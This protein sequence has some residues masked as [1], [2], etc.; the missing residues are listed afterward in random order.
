MT[1]A[2]QFPSLI[3]RAFE[4]GER[5]VVGL[6][7]D[8]LGFCGERGLRLDWQDDQCRVHWLGLEPND[9][10]EI[11]LG[12]SV[13]RAMLARIAALCN[14][15]TP[16]SV[17]AYGGEGELSIPTDRPAVF[18]VEFANTPGEQWMEV[19]RVSAGEKG[20][21]LDSAPQGVGHQ[22]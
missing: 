6:V 19:A 12:K 4:P 9:F 5:G 8:L 20:S 10:A 21:A 14:E 22:G 13:F 2:F 3:R 16:N 1:D 7:D 11:P 18:H 15:R 17:S